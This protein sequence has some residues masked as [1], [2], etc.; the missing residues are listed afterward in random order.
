M[1]YTKVCCNYIGRG[2]PSTFTPAFFFII[3]F[4]IADKMNKASAIHITDALS[5]AK[6][7]SLSFL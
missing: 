6:F 3:L 4:Q 1:K 5:S 2:E 7:I